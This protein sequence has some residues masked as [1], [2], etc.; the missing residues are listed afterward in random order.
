MLVEQRTD[1]THPGKRRDYLALHEAKGLEVQQLSLGRTDG[2]SSK[3]LGS[4]N[5]IGR[6][7]T[8]SDF[9]ERASLSARLM[10]EPQRLACVARMFALLQS[11]ES[12]F[13]TP[14]TFFTPLW[15]SPSTVA[16]PQEIS[17]AV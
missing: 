2:Y 6:L 8:R 13:L 10:A 12:K 3:E 1:T 11:Q 16:T 9:N 15:Q 4:L 5:Q 14:A 17:H 7:W